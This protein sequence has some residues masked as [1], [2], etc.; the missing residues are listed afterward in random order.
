VTAAA[1]SASPA[2]IAVAFT[3]I[4]RG[5]GVNVPT[6]STHTF[7]AALCATGL[8]ERDTTYWV[9]RSTLIRRMEDIALYDRAF[10]VFFEGH[11]STGV[12]DVAEAL[13]ITIAVDSDDGDDADSSRRRR[14]C[15][16]RTSP[17]TPPTNSPRRRS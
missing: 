6:S 7:A 16:T 5:L 3:Q 13:S 1:T 12:D 2:D 4:L 9:G 14:S 15:D 17:T 11:R 8:G 10:A